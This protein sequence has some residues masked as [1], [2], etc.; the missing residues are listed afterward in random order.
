MDFSEEAEAEEASAATIPE[1]TAIF[2]VGSHGNVLVTQTKQAKTPLEYNIIPINFTKLLPSN[3]QEVN[4]ELFYMGMVPQG[5]AATHTPHTINLFRTVADNYI[6]PILNSTDDRDTKIGNIRQILPTF[7]IEY[8]KLIIPHIKILLQTATDKLGVTSTELLIDT[9]T[10][11]NSKKLKVDRLTSSEVPDVMND[12]TTLSEEVQDLVNLLCALLFNPA[13]VVWCAFIDKDN[14]RIY[15]KLFNSM[16]YL[17]EETPKEYSWDIIC[18]LLGEEFGLFGNPAKTQ[19]FLPKLPQELLQKLEITNV[20]LIRTVFLRPEITKVVMI[21][22]SCAIVLNANKPNN[23]VTDKSV[24]HKIQADTDRLLG[25]NKITISPDLAQNVATQVNALVV[26]DIVLLELLNA[27]F[28]EH[29]NLASLS[30]SV[31]NARPG[32]SKPFQSFIVNKNI[33]LMTANKNGL[34]YHDQLDRFLREIFRQKGMIRQ[35]SLPILPSKAHDSLPILPSKA[36]ELNVSLRRGASVQGLPRDLR[37]IDDAQLMMAK[38][39][40]KKRQVEGGSRR[41]NASKKSMKRK[42]NRSKQSTKQSIRRRL[43]RRRITR[44]RV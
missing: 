27:S 24:I 19:Q 36:H 20:D 31:L 1:N 3:K 10:K 29:G 11:V 41:K 25:V 9:N 28:I 26:S 42:K 33:E 34:L 2:T 16:R 44:K 12:I 43:K 21:D 8:T 37:V 15:K 5:Y 40:L 30:E 32:M 7:L 17:L 39:K 22:G 18:Q 6:I 38:E 35:K 23:H 4:C 14:P 13:S